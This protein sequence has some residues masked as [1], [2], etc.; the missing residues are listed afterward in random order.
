MPLT[1]LTARYM[2]P[3]EMLRSCSWNL[4][5]SRATCTN[6]AKS[7][8]GDNWTHFCFEK[9]S[10]FPLSDHPTSCDHSPKPWPL[11]PSP[12]FLPFDY[13]MKQSVLISQ[14]WPHL[15]PCL[16]PIRWPLINKA[17]NA[18]TLAPNN[19]PEHL[20][21]MMQSLFQGLY[22]FLELTIFAVPAFVSGINR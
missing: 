8:R 17:S 21:S 3:G 19:Q 10:R 13:S 15:R 22:L 2:A 18:W 14:L 20:L 1:S 6:S 7:Q 11:N 5:M 16:L 4:K 12:E 9:Y